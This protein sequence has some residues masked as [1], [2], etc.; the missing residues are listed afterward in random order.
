MYRR[1]NDEC[2][3]NERQNLSVVQ[4]WRCHLLHTC[5]AVQLIFHDIVENR[6]NQN[7]RGHENLYIPLILLITFGPGY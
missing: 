2:D 5:R 6:R 1:K 3:L 7:P 4:Q